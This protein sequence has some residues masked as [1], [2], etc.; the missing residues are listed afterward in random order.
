MGNQGSATEGLRRGVELAWAGTMGELREAHIWLA[1]GDGPQERP[2]DAAAGSAGA[3][4]GPVARPGALS[5]VSPGVRARLV[6][7]VAGLRQRRRGR[8]GLPHGEHGLSGP[9]TGLA[10]EGRSGGQARHAGR[11]PRRGRGLGDPSGDVS[12][13]DRGQVRFPG[14]R[15]P[16]AGEADLVQRRAQAAQGRAA[17]PH[18]DRM[19]LPGEGHA[20]GHLHLVPVEHA[21]GTAAQGQ[22]P[23]I[24]RSGAHAAAL[25]RP[26]RRV[27]PRL[28]GRPEAVLQ[29]RHRRA[30][31][32]DGPVGPRG[33]AGPGSRSSTIR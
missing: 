26:S 23:G 8:H 24:P 21:A 18:H 27:D 32:R 33:L 20:R 2:K 11:D 22:V 28:Q 12:A 3:S 29:F 1:N 16:A 14:P 6:A 31:D 19:G 4:L 5:P 17:R 25:A 7:Q 30:D 10:V 15:Q 9:A 13:P